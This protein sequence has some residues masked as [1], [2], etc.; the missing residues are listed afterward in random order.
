MARLVFLIGFAFA[1]VSHNNMAMKT[2]EPGVGPLSALLSF[3]AENVR[4]YRDKVHL[5]LLA[6]RMSGE[7]IARELPT[8]SARI[9]RV[10]PAAGVFGANASGKTTILRALADMRDLVMSSF[11]RGGEGSGVDRRP[12]LLDAGSR[13]RPSRFEVD[14]ILREVR[15][16]YG[17]EI[18]DERILHEYAYYF[19]RG[20][21]SLVFQRGVDG[22]EFGPRFRMTGKSLRRLVRENALVLSVAGAAADEEIGPLFSWFQRNLL[23]ADLTTRGIRAAHTAD[24]LESDDHRFRVLDLLLAADLGLSNLERAP[25]DSDFADRMRRAL[26]ILRGIEGDSDTPDDGDF[27]VAEF[28]RLAHRGD[29]DDVVFDPQDESEGTLVWVG[30]IGPVLDALDRGDV[31]L[32]DELDASLHPHLV[33]RLVGLFQDPSTNPGCAQLIFNSHDVTVLG[34]SEARALERDQIWFTE[35]DLSGATKLIQLADYRPRR[36]E[37]LQRRYLQGR[38]GGVPFLDPEDFARSTR[39]SRPVRS[40]ERYPFRDP[41]GF[42]HDFEPLD[43]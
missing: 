27:V 30:L 40:A 21:Q 5:S 20:R 22:I 14:L 24:M 7:E 17:L 43:S 41:E 42:A 4:S 19:P 9:V 38:Y 28:I 8:A 33:Q 34:D 26:R 18:D 37:A 32:T 6:T 36:D 1:R 10:L 23:L 2:A 16:L 12:F 39:R 11:R 3:T 15:W 13:D 31:L 29:G 35:K 25:V